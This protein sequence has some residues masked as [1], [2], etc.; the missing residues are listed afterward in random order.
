M[1]FCIKILN[2]SLWSARFKT[3]KKHR[4]PAWG[5]WQPGVWRLESGT[6]VLPPIPG[7][8]NGQ[9]GCSW[10]TTCCLAREE[11]GSDPVMHGSPLSSSWDPEIEETAPLLMFW[12]PLAAGPALEQK[13]NKRFSTRPSSGGGSGA[14]TISRAVSSIAGSPVSGPL[15]L[16]LAARFGGG[17]DGLG[18]LSATG[19]TT[20][21][22]GRLLRG[23][24]G[25]RRGA[26]TVTSR[27]RGCS[28]S[29]SSRFPPPHDVLDRLCLLLCCREL[30]GKAL[31]SVAEEAGLWHGSIQELYF[32]LLLHVS[33]TQPEMALLD[34]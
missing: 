17:L 33:E 1:H 26:P 9:E 28:R 15:S 4:N 20:L 8:T 13:Q 7:S 34:H 2:G 16:A 19:S 23:S 22:G 3:R 30:L 5:L 12:V 14:V 10:A 6:R 27:L 21:P 18:V 32:L 25:G 11:E 31:D 24:R 29:G